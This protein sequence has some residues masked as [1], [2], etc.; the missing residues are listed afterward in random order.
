MVWFV[1]LV[2]GLSFLL[3]LVEFRSFFIPVKAALMN[4]LP[5]GA[6]YGI[7]V[8]V[9]GRWAWWMPRWFDRALPR[10][11]VEPAPLD[12]FEYEL[13]TVDPAVPGEQ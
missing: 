3:L 12:L 8:A 2:I 4:L 13:D 11:N 1:G 10:I 7:V 9:A 6:A 5:V